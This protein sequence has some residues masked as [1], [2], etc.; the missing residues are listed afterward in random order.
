M[1]CYDDVQVIKYRDIY[2]ASLYKIDPEEN[3]VSMF[4]S[5]ED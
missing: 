3:I 5:D 2:C 1:H 4:P